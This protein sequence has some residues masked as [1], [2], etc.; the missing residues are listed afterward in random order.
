M[1]SGKFPA[2]IESR[3]NPGA[4]CCNTYTESLPVESTETAI[5]EDELVEELAVRVDEEDRSL[6]QEPIPKI[7]KTDRQIRQTPVGI[8]LMM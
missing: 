1:L 3:K 8:F 5:V 2:A 6:L 7:I 4:H